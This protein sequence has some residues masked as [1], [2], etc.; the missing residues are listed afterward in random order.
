M[1]LMSLCLQVAQGRHTCVQPET[2]CM[3]GAIDNRAA[4]VNQ[5]GLCLSEHEQT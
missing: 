5:Q 1:T 2:E 3:R 4:A